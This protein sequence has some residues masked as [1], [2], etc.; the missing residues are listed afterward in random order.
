MLELQGKKGVWIKMPI[1][2]SNL[3]DPAVKVH[4]YISLEC[5]GTY[6][7][8]SAGKEAGLPSPCSSSKCLIK[9]VQ[10]LHFMEDCI[11]E[12]KEPESHAPKL[13]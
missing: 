5:Y 8:G 4:G 2:L 10:M 3:V 12:V 6:M 9:L 7:V 13:T 1:R 11:A